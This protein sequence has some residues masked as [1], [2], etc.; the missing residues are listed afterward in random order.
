MQKRL[1]L[2]LCAS[3]PNDF[4]QN[5]RTRAARHAFW[6]LRGITLKSQSAIGASQ[7]RGGSLDC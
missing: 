2:I 7:G 5:S 3:H 6:G 4:L 1:K